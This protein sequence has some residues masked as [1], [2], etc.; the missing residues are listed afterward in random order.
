MIID[1]KKWH[2]LAVKNLSPLLKRI[3]HDEDFY[4]LNCLHSFR[5]KSKLRKHKTICKKHNYC[6]TEKP[7][8]YNNILKN[9]HGEKF[10]KV[11][12]IINANLKSLLAKINTC[13]NNPENSSTTK[14]NKQTASGY[15]LFIHCSFVVTK[16]I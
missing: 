11:P 4:C 2:Y 8:E 14:I 5:K 16:K 13:H 12:F 3:I 7:K 1:G 6:Y 9:K 15:F 10:M